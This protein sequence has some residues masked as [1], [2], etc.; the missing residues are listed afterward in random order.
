MSV[1]FL[2][3]SKTQNVRAMNTKDKNAC[4]LHRKLKA[5]RFNFLF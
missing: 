1:I 2:N 4:F 3:L 5:N